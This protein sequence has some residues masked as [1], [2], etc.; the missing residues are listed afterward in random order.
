VQ[1]QVHK[2]HCRRF[3]QQI[4]NEGKLDRIRDFIAPDAWN[5]EVGDELAPP[6]RSPEYFADLIRLYREAFPDLRVEILDQIAENGRVVTSLRLQGTQRNPLLGIPSH[7]KSM[8]I[9]GIRIDRF[10]GDRIAESWFQWDSVGMLRQLGVLPNLWE[11]Q[12]EGTTKA[13]GPAAV[14]YFSPPEEQPGLV[15]P[16]S[17]WMVS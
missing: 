1:N 17:Q 4:F 12:A 2:A 13:P 9:D 8:E 16:H 5:H 6:G 3:I 11:G 14:W 7:G 15:E 10:V